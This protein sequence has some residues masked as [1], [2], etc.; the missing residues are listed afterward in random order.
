MTPDLPKNDGKAQPFRPSGDGIAALL[1]APESDEGVIA[2]AAF[3]G[4]DGC[5]TLL[6]LVAPSSNLDLERRA[7]GVFLLGRLHCQD[8]FKL[9]PALMQE[10][11][12]GIQISLAYALVEIDRAQGEK[13]LLPLIKDEKA[14]TLLREHAIYAVLAG[15][16][17]NLRALLA[18][19]VGGSPDRRLRL[20]LMGW[21]TVDAPDPFQGPDGQ[22]PDDEC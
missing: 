20:E 4:A 1:D 16:D 10:G 15:A 8:L 3:Y 13:L 7:R 22:S 11:V 12:L 9:A 18:E 19:I 2:E 14:D 21:L 6:E 17:R 5:E